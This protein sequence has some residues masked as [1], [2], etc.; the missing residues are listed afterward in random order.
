MRDH[1]MSAEPS[2]RLNKIDYQNTPNPYES[3]YGPNWHIEVKKSSLLICYACVSDMIEHILIEMKRVFKG[4]THKNYC[5]LNHDFLSLMTSK[6][7][8]EWIKEKV[9]K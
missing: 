7:T 2:N 1:V 6:E 9:Y 5:L 4:T 3:Q 8:C